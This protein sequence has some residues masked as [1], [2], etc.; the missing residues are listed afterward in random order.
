M[1]PIL[2][3]D[4]SLYADPQAGFDLFD[5]KINFLKEGPDR[6][7]ISLKNGET[8]AVK[9]RC[10]HDVDK[11]TNDF[12]LQENGFQY[13]TISRDLLITLNQLEQNPF[14][15]KNRFE[16]LSK[17]HQFLSAWGKANGIPG[18]AVPINLTYRT[19]D[20]TD[21]A[22]P[23]FFFA[24]ADYDENDISNTMRTHQEVFKR[25]I[26]IETGILSEETYQGLKIYT[27]LNLWMPLNQ[28]PT[29][30]TLAVMDTRSVEN[31]SEQLRPAMTKGKTNDVTSLGLRACENQIWVAQ[32][33]MIRGDG[34]I[35]KTMKT[36]HTAVDIE[37][38]FPMDFCDPHRKSVE[39]RCAFIEIPDELSD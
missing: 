24:H 2:N 5:A 8:K 27:M 35:F 23:P 21:K 28:H 29:I 10:Y 31:L 3:T 7:N 39:V 37:S 13:C 30:N 34:V 20:A 1:N 25:N 38:R 19:T 36:P 32:K 9:I 18:T 4:Y 15:K 12:N 22:T 33:V 26:E 14:S 16:A 11:L 6:M 17:T